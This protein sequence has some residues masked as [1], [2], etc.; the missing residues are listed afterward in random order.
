[1]II[2]WSV[3]RVMI[4]EPESEINIYKKKRKWIE[5]KIKVLKGYC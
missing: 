2:D 4:C 1:M 5:H 3:P